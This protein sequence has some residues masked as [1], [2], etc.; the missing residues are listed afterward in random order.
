[1]H[2]ASLKNVIDNYE[3]LLGVW[4]EAQSGRLDGEMK[5]RIIGI[6]TQMHTFRVWRV[7]R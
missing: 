5:A 6:E 4:E 2:A 1:M 7:S 3:V